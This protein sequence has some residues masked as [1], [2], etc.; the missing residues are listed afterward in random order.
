MKA[1]HTLQLEKILLK[2]ETRIRKFL[3]PDYI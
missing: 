1:D 2:T 3:K